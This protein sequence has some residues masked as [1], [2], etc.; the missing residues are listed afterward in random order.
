M[1]LVADIGGTKTDLAVFAE[2][3]GPHAALA[4]ARLPS[5]DYASLEALVQAFLAQAQQPVTRAV[6]AVPGPVVSG[7]ANVTNLP[8]VL[9]EEQL[10]SALGLR[11]VRL[12]NDL[13]AVARA[14][15]LLRPTDLAPV[16]AGAPV[17]GGAIAVVA[18]GTGLGQ[19]YLTWDGHRY[20]AHP[21]EGGHTDFGAQGALQRELLAW[22]EAR[23]GH[24]SYERVCSGMAVPDLYTFLRER[25]E[26]RESPQ[27][28]RL[29]ADV[30]DR[31]PLIVQAGMDSTPD[32]LSRRALELMVDIL[33][34]VAGN[35]ALT[36]LA[37]GGVYLGGGMSLHLQSM[38]QDGRFLRTFCDKGRF[39][40]FMHRL[41]VH[42][43]LHP[44][45]ALL[46]VASAGL[47]GDTR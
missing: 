17:P 24:V 47:S 11:S 12:M 25:G 26:A 16:N 28:A 1:L 41:P 9:D 44:R 7:R 13:A 31:T 6:F 38:L 45:A 46:G 42:V 40:A 8:W 27:L 37:T 18:P 30:E 10:A 29:L 20:H 23:H 35:L 3:S 22:M 43:I 21:S 14:V 32:P 19:A 39:K 5:G 4:E 36:A 15:P 34:A 2:E 33:G